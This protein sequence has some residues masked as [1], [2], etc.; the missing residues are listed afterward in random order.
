MQD[1]NEWQIVFTINTAVVS[2]AAT[3]GVGQHQASLQPPQVFEAL[4]VKYSPAQF[5]ADFD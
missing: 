5:L 3:H 4:H 2:E 1:S